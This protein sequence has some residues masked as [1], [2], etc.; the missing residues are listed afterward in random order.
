[1]LKPDLILT[2][3]DDPAHSLLPAI[4]PTV[5]VPI[6]SDLPPEKVYFKENLRYVAKVLGQ[7]TRTEEALNQYQQ[8]IEKIKQRLGNQ[9]QQMEIAV[10]FCD[11]NVAWTIGNKRHLIINSIFNDL[12]LNYRSFSGKEYAKLSLETIDDYNTDILFIVDVAER[13]SSFYYQHP[14]FSSLKAF[15]NHQAYVVSQETWYTLGILGANKILDDLE[16][17]LVSPS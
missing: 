16:K 1:M 10:L 12:G 8:R 11:S 4:A 15:K 3:C 7:E 9:L 5:P 6:P 14:L 2:C 13:T 17:Y